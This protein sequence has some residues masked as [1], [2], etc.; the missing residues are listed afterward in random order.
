MHY[1]DDDYTDPWRLPETV[2]LHHGNAKSSR[3]WYAWVPML[4]RQYRVVRPDARGFG[5][6]SVPPEGYDWSLS[7]FGSDLLALLDYLELDK[8][9][10]IGETVGGT[11][12]LQ[13]AHEHPERLKSLTVCTSPY[14]F[15]GVSTYQD[16]YRLVQEEGVAGWARATGDRRV[17]PNSD[18]A[19][20]QWYIEQMSNTSQRVVLET[21]AYLSTQDL[22]RHTAPHPHADPH[23]GG[24]RQRS[25]QPR[26]H[27]RNGATAAQ[28]PP[29]GNTGNR[30][31]RPALSPG[32]MRRRLAGIR[33]RHSLGPVHP[34]HPLPHSGEGRNP[35]SAWRRER[36]LWATSLDSGLRR[37][38]G[39]RSHQ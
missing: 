21:L 5:R 32:K 29:A 30:R 25:Q 23:H 12:S 9:H 35:E 28:R 1:E 34:A 38:D 31:L 20:H 33:R 16:Y 14:K 27:H 8:V 22:F 15:A 26:P 36:N 11:I 7:N 3:L 24:G 18:P 10:L 2:V 4:A 19:H 37:K 39:Q 17:D 13:F 6:S